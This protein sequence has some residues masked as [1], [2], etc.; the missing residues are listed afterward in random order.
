MMIQ[1]RKPMMWMG[2]LCVCVVFVSWTAVSFGG[3]KPTAAHGISPETVADY[4]HAIIKADRTV[5][6][7]LVVKRMQE[8]GIVSAAEHWEQHNAL[9]D[10][11]STRLNS[12]HTDISRM[13]SSA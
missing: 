10:R 12:S 1:L 9:P 13:P 3:K 8:K 5:Y 2:A 4:L 6:T 7:T 11:K